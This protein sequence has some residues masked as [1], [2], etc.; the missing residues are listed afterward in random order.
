MASDAEPD[1]Q[2]MSPSRTRWLWVVAIFTWFL[3]DFLL[4]FMGGFSHQRQ[5]LPFREKVTLFNII[6]LCNCMI[7]GVLVVMQ[8]VLCPSFVTNTFMSS[9]DELPTIAVSD[10]QKR[11]MIALYGDIMVVK[12]TLPNY[13]NLRTQ[14]LGRDVSPYPRLQYNS[15]TKCNT[16]RNSRIRELRAQSRTGRIIPANPDISIFQ[17]SGT[18]SSLLG[19]VAIDSNVLQTRTLL[20]SP[21]IWISVQGTVF[22]M[23]EY[24]S[25]SVAPFLDPAT[26]QFILDNAGKQVSQRRLESSTEPG[27]FSCLKAVFSIG[28][29]DY[30]ADTQ[31]KLS[32]N[33]LTGLLLF[34]FCIIYVKFVSSIRI[35]NPWRKEKDIRTIPRAP[36]LVFVPYYTESE[37]SVRRTLQ[38]VCDTNYDSDKKLVFVV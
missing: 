28:L 13:D 32:S 24:F 26:E 16:L 37:E 6:I 15:Y 17:E 23:T 3:P 8:L 34:V 18:Y 1:V 10:P 22:N 12:P 20:P 31:C 33:I 35:Q 25:G 11:F 27:A 2:E 21:G 5:Y 7:F 19:N 14:W 38:S 4:S 9:I 29:V 30:R 36:L